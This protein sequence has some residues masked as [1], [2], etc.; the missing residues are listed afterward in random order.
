MLAR[1]HV[2]TGWSLT[3]GHELSTRRAKTLQ[4]SIVFA[5]VT[6]GVFLVLCFAPTFC[7]TVGCLEGVGFEKS[8]RGKEN[9]IQSLNTVYS[10]HR[11]DKLL[12]DRSHS[13]LA[14][15]SSLNMNFY[16]FEQLTPRGPFS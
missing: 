16:I 7:V 11:K 9:L 14:G 15:T 1:S 12:S 13:T 3:R 2:A 6:F 5:C 8:G 4:R 10:T